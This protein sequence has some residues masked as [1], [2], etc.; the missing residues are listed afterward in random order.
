M[1]NFFK[2]K[3]NEETWDGPII[4]IRYHYRL[5]DIFREINIGIG[6]LFK[7]GPTRIGFYRD[8]ISTGNQNHHSI[9]VLPELNFLKFRSGSGQTGFQHLT[10]FRPDFQVGK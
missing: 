2:V 6:I 4:G 10:G 3:L 7:L 8:W 9:F 5:I 1:I